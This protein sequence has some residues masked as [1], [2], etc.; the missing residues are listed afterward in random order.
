MDVFRILVVDDDNSIRRM[1]GLILGKSGHTIDEAGNGV[2]ALAKV[3]KSVP[4]LLITDVMMPEM[5]GW[6]LVRTLRSSPATAFLPVIF[7]TALGD[8]AERIRGFRLG[9]DDY[10]AK[11]FHFEELSMRVRG[12]LRRAQ[13]AREATRES[14]VQ[15]KG[16][17]G[18]LGDF[19][20]ASLLVMLELERKSGRLS[21]TRNDESV[22]VDVREGRIVRATLE[23]RGDIRGAGCIAYLLTWSDGAFRFTPGA[24]EGED[25]VNASTTQLLLDG[26]R[27]IDELNRG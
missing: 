8:E 21:L 22:A 10:V 4:D 19:G 5:D 18:S 6:T 9:A 27:Q 7:L 20:V 11:P 3:A 14:L 17:G 2:E 25:E 12:V 24:V 1:L 26:A 23:G 13:S 15:H 16:L